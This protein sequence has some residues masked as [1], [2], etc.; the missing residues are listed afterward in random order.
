MTDIHRFEF[1]GEA[2]QFEGFDWLLECR[3]LALSAGTVERRSPAG[4]SFLLV[5]AGTHDIHAGGGSWMRRGIRD[6][7]DAGRPL[8]IFLPPD[9]PYR[10]EHGSGSA[11]VWSVRQPELPEPESPRQSLST[12]PLLPMAG[13]GKAFDPATGTWKPKEA[14][15]ASPEA[16]LPRRIRR[17]EHDGVGVERILDADYKALGLML[18][19]VVL[20]DGETLS[21]LTP[22]RPACEIGIYFEADVGLTIGDSERTGIGVVAVSGSTVPT[23]RSAGGRAY[24]SIVYAGPDA[25]A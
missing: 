2:A 16:I 13:S 5:L 4:E 3:R 7:P 20:E 10:L 9:T 22:E 15:L 23:L 25:S 21:G 8:G 6:R 18:D 14:F 1:D 24:A 11:L 17:F 12:K 19:E